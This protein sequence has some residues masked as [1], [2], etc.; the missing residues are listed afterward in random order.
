[1]L[2]KSAIICYII[3]LLFAVLSSFCHYNSTINGKNIEMSC[4]LSVNI[5]LDAHGHWWY[6]RLHISAWPILNLWL[7]FSNKKKNFTSTNLLGKR[8]VFE[9]CFHFAGTFHL[10]CRNGYLN[11]KLKWKWKWMLKFWQYF[12]NKTWDF[13]FVLFFSLQRLLQWIVSNI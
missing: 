12:D 13:T 8:W 9:L 10:F 1:M 4:I 5:I 3:R 7:V 6:L 11:L 2:G